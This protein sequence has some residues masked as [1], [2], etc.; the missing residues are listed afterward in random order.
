MGLTGLR[1]AFGAMFDSQS[2]IANQL[3]RP[4]PSGGWGDWLLTIPRRGQGVYP[5]HGPSQRS[6]SSTDVPLRR[7]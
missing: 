7:A 6:V 1:S 3:R 4:S 2:P 5:S